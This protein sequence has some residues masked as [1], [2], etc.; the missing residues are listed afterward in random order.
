MRSWRSPAISREELIGKS[1]NIVRHPDM[2]PQ[3]FKWLWDTLKSER[4]WRGM[5]KNR[6]KNGD[7][8]WVRATIAP[9]IE[10]G[11]IVG[12]VSVRRAPTREQVAEA[13]A[14]YRDLE[15]SGAQVLS[16]YERF[17]FK[18]WSLIAKLQ[19][20]I[21]MSLVIVLSAAQVFVSANLREESHTLAEE[22]GDATRQPDH[23]QRQHADGD[24]TDR[25]GGQSQTAASARSAPA[26]TSNRRRSCA[27]SRWSICTVPACRKS[28]SRTMCSAK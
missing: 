5:V 2:P 14:L 13:E 20:L 7:H 19:F 3:A 16:R 27:P 4:P 8:Y 6:C 15:Q 28:T 17:K 18:N 1:H 10:N 26:S 12:Y 23:R 24:R 11:A 9:I 21:Q 22:K 25:R